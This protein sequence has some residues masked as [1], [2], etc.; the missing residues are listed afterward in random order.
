MTSTHRLNPSKVFAFQIEKSHRINIPV[1]IGDL[2]HNIQ[3]GNPFKYR[4]LVY[5]CYYKNIP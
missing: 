4:V 2:I 1:V 3:N 5:Y